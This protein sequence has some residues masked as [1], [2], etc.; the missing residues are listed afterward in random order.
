MDNE[1]QGILVS[2]NI[3]PG[4]IPKLPVEEVKVTVDGLEGDGHDHKK[5]DKPTR[6]LSLFDIEILDQIR[7]EGYDIKPGAAGENL[8]VQSLHVQKMQP[9][10]VL[11]FSGGVAIELTEV[12]KPCFVLDSIN[13][14]FKEDVKDRIGFM[15]QVNKTGI[16]RPGE[17]IQVIPPQ[18]EKES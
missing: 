18:D 5:H 6:A 13:P 2:V 8:T 10:T 12:R 17:K 1:N 7:A 11:N 4:G 9:G 14:K 15:A 16:I 3:S